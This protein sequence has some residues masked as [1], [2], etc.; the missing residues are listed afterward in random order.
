MTTGGAGWST[1]EIN[2]TYVVAG[3]SGNTGS[4]VAE[5]L[6][7]EGKPV[8]VI[9]RDAAKGEPWRAKGA[10]VAVAS[11]DDAA[12][13][14]KAL[15]GATGAYLLVP[16][17]HA[18]NFLATQRAVT[19][20]IATALENTPVPHVVFLSSIGANLP[21]GTGPIVSVAYAEQRLGKVKNVH[22]TF[23]RPTYFMENLGAS[24]GGI[25]N[26]V[27]ATFFDPSRAFPMI[28]TVDIG[29]AAARRLIEGASVSSVLQ[30]AGPSE[31]T[32]A[33]LA[34]TFGDVVGKDLRLEVGPTSFMT[35]VLVGAGLPRELAGLYQ[36][37]TESFNS[38]AITFEASHPLQRGATPLATVARSLVGVA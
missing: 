9:V 37:M 31:L 26:G 1:G 38:G 33:D 19:E 22:F 4:V 32:P 16:P 27:F 11:L 7:A 30:L 24:L 21:G 35:D 18:A 20:A 12:A 34:R 5:T 10:E 2:M 28:A 29:R 3:V 15:S 17:N 13:L 36:E 23:L 25:A 6:L 8:R 14:S